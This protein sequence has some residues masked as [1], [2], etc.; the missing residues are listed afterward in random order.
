MAARFASEE[1]ADSSAFAAINTALADR[2]AY[3]ATTTT[4]EQKAIARTNIGAVAAADIG[5]TSTFDP[6]AAFNL[7]LTGGPN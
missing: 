2:V 4:S 1:T 5:D 6:V 7:A 3:T